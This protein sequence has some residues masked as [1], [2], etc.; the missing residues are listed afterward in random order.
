MGEPACGGKGGGRE[1]EEEEEEDEEEEQE[2]EEEERHNSRGASVCLWPGKQTTHRAGSEKGIGHEIGH[3]CSLQR[4]CRSNRQG[5]GL[6]FP[7]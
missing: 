1:E 6:G 2:D 7:H 5:Q 3:V 4:P